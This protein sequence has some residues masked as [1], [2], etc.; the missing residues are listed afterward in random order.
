MKKK[1]F[2]LLIIIMSFSFI[3]CSQNEK[4]KVIKTYQTT[5][6]ENIQDCFD[7]NQSVVIVEYS[8][9]SNGT[10]ECKDINYRYRLEISGRMGGA[11]KDSTYVYLSNMENISF[12]QAWKA[13]GYS[14]DMNDYF[15]AKDAK[16]VEM[17]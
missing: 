6:A 4:V 2:S 14:S 12:E 7:K 17:K 13:A 5:D 11:V 8:E 16:L 1:L 10:W 3:G 15:D 9:L